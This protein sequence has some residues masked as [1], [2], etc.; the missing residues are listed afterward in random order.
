MN[1]SIHC[2]RTLCDWQKTM[3]LK[4]PTSERTHWIR[5]EWRLDSNFWALICGK[6]IP[7]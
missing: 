1:I 6:M 7:Q 3:N 5:C 2:T 4:L